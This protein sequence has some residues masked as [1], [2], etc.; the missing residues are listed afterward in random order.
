M[1]VLQVHN[2]Y[3][4]YGGEDVV[5]NNEFRLLQ[6]NGVIVQQ[7]Q[8]DNSNASFSNSIYNGQSAKKLNDRINIFKPDII[9]AHNLFYTASPSILFEAKRNNVPVVVTLHNY[10]LICPSA[11]LLRDSK[12]CLKCKNK[13]FPFPSIRHSCFQDSAL[14]SLA[15]SI[16]LSSHHFLNTWTKKIDKIIVLTPFAKNLFID[17]HLKFNENDL[18]VKSNSTDDIGL[19]QN[20][21]K[22]VD[23]LYV[24]RLSEEKGVSSLIKAFNEL[25]TLKLHI[26][27]T[28]DLERSLKEISKENIVFHGKKEFSFVTTMYKSSKALLFPSVCFEGLPNT[29]IEAFS[30]GLPVISSNVDNINQIITSG[31]NGFTFEANNSLSL[32]RSI[33]QFE[34][35]DIGEMK[36]NAR[37]TY[38][39]KYTH[40]HNFKSLFRV[41][42]S[43]IG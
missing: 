3:R 42:K 13:I 16:S 14:K 37:K 12:P 8:F 33:L 10:R 31:Y 39:D 4:Y 19:A 22:E 20:P 29:I 24:G 26:I 30:A 40:Q 36:E 25:P 23:Y 21:K 28:G 1:K 38:L 17:S 5:V 11:L 6:D 9:H 32:I 15:L 2:K 41:Y 43:L 27:G 35:M 18:I 34:E 7:L